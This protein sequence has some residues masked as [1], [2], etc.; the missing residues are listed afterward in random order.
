MNISDSE[1]D[2]VI[3]TLGP[4]IDMSRK[5]K[6]TSVADG[7]ELIIKAMKKFNKKRLMMLATPALQSKDDRK[8]LSTVIPGILAKIFLPNGYTE[9][10]RLELLILMSN[11]KGNLMII[12][13]GIGHVKCPYPGKMWPD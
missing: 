11:T 12:H 10:K 3:S 7:L 2:A 8:N 5:L 13:S 6:G 1:A 9:M 4:P